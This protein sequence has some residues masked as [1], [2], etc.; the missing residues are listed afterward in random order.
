VCQSPRLADIDR[1]LVAGVACT[2]VASR[3]FTL[4][5]RMA[6]QRHKDEHL[7]GVLVKAHEQED[8]RLALDVVGQLRAIN[9]ASLAVLK[10][11]RERGDGE[12][13][14]KAV[15]RVQKQIELQAKLLGELDERPQV[16]VLALPEWAQVRLLVLQALEPHPEARA[17]VAGRLAALEVGANGRT[18]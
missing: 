15:D 10:Q 5:A 16:N 13:A 6:V 17:A 7:P 9:Q 14:L 4:S 8:V 2:A 12:L 1:D 3:Y 11:A 18:G